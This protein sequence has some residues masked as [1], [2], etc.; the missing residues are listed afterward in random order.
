MKKNTQYDVWRY[1]HLLNTSKK[2]KR[3]TIKNVKNCS[4]KRQF[5]Q[6]TCLFRL[7]LMLQQGTL[8]ISARTWKFYAWYIKLH[9]YNSCIYFNCILY[10]LQKYLSCLF[11]LKVFIWQFIKFGAYPVWKIF[12]YCLTNFN[13]V[14]DIVCVKPRTEL[15][16]LNILLKQNIFPADIPLLSHWLQCWPWT[17]HWWWWCVPL[18]PPT[19]FKRVPQLSTLYLLQSLENP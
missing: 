10:T 6:F 5:F 13:S 2:D 9:N 19:T 3:V 7:T 15:Q 16:S 12:M 8:N 4:F 14:C 11:C 17:Y 18:T 1:F